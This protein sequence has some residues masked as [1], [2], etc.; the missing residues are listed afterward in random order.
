MPMGIS[1]FGCKTQRRS[2]NHS[3]QVQGMHIELFLMGQR[4]IRH[5][6]NLGEGVFFKSANIGWW[7]EELGR[8]GEH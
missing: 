1:N 5:L 3:R 2:R 4:V 6:V 8:V 7:R